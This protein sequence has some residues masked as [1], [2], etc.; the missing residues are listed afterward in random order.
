MKPPPLR[1]SAI[2]ESSP[3][4]L[5]G[6]QYWEE[7]EQ[8]QPQQLTITPSAPP[9]SCSETDIMLGSSSSAPVMCMNRSDVYLHRPIGIVSDTPVLAVAVSSSDP[10]KRGEV[11]AYAQVY[12]GEQV[13]EEAKV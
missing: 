13:E 11:V 1:R 6:V 3:V 9:I 4:Q 8:P 5:T 2:G 10:Y 7:Q 12:T